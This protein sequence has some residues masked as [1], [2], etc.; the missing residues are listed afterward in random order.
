MRRISNGYKTIRSQSRV[1][2]TA[3]E[4]YCYIYS[5]SD[6]SKQLIVFLYLINL[7]HPIMLTT[8]WRRPLPAGLD[9]ELRGHPNITVE[10]LAFLTRCK[11]LLEIFPPA[12]PR[13]QRPALIYTILVPP[14]CL[15]V[16]VGMMVVEGGFTSLTRAM[17]FAGVP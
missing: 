17:F 1:R 4:T 6:R 9:C 15:L 2:P 7:G 16:L 10:F 13:L 3:V 14:L 12:N 5:I 8:D 11:F